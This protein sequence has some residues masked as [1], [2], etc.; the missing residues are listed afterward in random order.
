MTDYLE[1]AVEAAAKEDNR[2]LLCETEA[3]MRAAEPFIAEHHRA[4]LQTVED[5]RDLARAGAERLEGMID[6]A[7]ADERARVEERAQP[8][9]QSL[10]NLADRLHDA[11]DTDRACATGAQFARS[12]ADELTA[13]L[14]P[15]P[16]QGDQEP[17]PE[18]ENSWER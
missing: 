17:A 10:R 7:P 1:K 4:E 6:Q 8:V 18:E 2:F 12:I 3:V 16:N 13:A 9:V 11:S 15:E 14:N 5:E